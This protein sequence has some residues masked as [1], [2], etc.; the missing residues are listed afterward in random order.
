MFVTGFPVIQP[1]SFPKA[2]MLPEKVTA[3]MSIPSMM[4]EPSLKGRAPACWRRK[5]SAPATIAEAPPP[6]PLKI[7]TISGM[8]VIFT[9]RAAAAPTR[10]PVMIPMMIHDHDRTLASTSVT[11]MAISMARAAIWFPFRAVA[12]EES[13][14]RPTTKRKAE[15]R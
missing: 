1:A 12:G 11:T 14:L 5:N 2:T 6:K 9:I 7:P 4:V 8:A 13:C 3:P 10:E 15:R